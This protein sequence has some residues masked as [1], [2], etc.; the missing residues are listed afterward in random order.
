MARKVIDQVECNTASA[1]LIAAVSAGSWE[2]VNGRF[3]RLYRTPSGKYFV[4]HRDFDGGS[5]IGLLNRSEAMVLYQRLD[6]HIL[7]FE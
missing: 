4:D 1:K 7:D 5:H 6:R 3:S 2:A